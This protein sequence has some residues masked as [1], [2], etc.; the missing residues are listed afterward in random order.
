MGTTARTTRT[1]VAAVGRWSEIGW[2]APSV[3]VGAEATGVSTASD[4]IGTASEE[5]EGVRRST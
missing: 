2:L 1:V 3:E 5:Q 4:N